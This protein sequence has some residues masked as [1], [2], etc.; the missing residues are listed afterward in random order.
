MAASDESRKRML[1]IGASGLLGSKILEQAGDTYDVS[2]TY[3]P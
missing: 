3:I 1:V 2:G